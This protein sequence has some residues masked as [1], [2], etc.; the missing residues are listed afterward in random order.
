MNIVFVASEGVPFAKTGGLAD[1]AGALPRAV[2]DLGHST[3]LFIPCYRKVWEANRDL[4]ATGITLRIPIGTSTVLGHVFEGRL[5]DSDVPVYLIDQPDYFDRDGFYG[6]LGH[7]FEDNC[8][9]FVFFQRAVLEAVVALGIKPDVFHCNDW[10]TGLLPV[11]LKSL[12]H[13][14]PELASAGCLFTIHN[15]AY[16]G[17][18]WH[19]DLPLTGLDWS[20]FNYRALEF[21]GKLSF[22]KA[23]LVFSDMLTTV[24]P[25]YASE[26]QAQR[27]GAGLDGLL[28]DRQADLRGIVNGIDERSWTPRHETMLAANYDVDTVATGKAACKAW[29]QRRAGLPVRPD[30]PLFAQ[31]GRLDPQKGWDLLAEVADRLLEHDVQLIVLGTGHP[32]YHNLLEALVHRHPGKVWAYLGFSD[33]L[34][35]QIEAGA[36]VFL[37]PSLFE[38]CG[39]NQLYSLAH[40]TV[41]VVHATGGLV[42]TVVDL[43]PQT[44]AEGRATGFVFHEPTAASVWRALERVL[45]TWS[46]RPTWEKLVKAGMS[47]D[48]S[49]KQSAGR[50]VELY[51]EIQRRRRPQ[52]AQPT[53]EKP[54]PA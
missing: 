20:Y 41:P 40:G 3:S 42:D 24:S 29:L 30:A 27:H 44:L 12:Y 33:D 32:K 36:D 39:L 51:H 22:M 14:I 10:Q 47:D 28:R 11:Y 13:N 34:A 7:D 16:Q 49:W 31:I 46:D 19:W 15:L 45:Q 2:A 5:P 26:I 48:W 18:F 8:E 38:P 17:L 9:R 50:Y 1:V 25:T 4:A 54:V 21:H 37:M 43:T 23:G 53:R 35:H 52:L 6:H